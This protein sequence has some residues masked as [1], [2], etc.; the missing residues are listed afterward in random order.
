MA[1]KSRYR[2]GYCDAYALAIHRLHDYP[3][4]VVRGYWYDP[5]WESE[6]YEDC[7]VVAVK[8]PGV[9]LDV[10][11]EHSRDDLVRRCLFGGPVERVEIEPVSEE[12]ARFLFTMEGVPDADIDEAA[13]CA[14][15]YGW[16][17]S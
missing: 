2:G 15:R 8:E 17:G 6:E 10:D 3:L 9:Y 13:T 7:H 14:L 1:S 11:G 12:E 5:E 4:A 16:P